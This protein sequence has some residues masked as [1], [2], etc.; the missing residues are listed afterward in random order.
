MLSAAAQCNCEISRSLVSALQCIV[1]FQPRSSKQ[2]FQHTQTLVVLYYRAIAILLADSLQPKSQSLGKNLTAFNA[3]IGFS[4]FVRDK[5]MNKCNFNRTD[6]PQLSPLIKQQGNDSEDIA[7]IL[8]AL[9]TL[10]ASLDTISLNIDQK[11][12]VEEDLIYT[13]FL[14]SCSQVAGPV[15]VDASKKLKQVINENG[16]VFSTPSLCKRDQCFINFID[17]WIKAFNINITAPIPAMMPPIA[18]SGAM[19]CYPSTTSNSPVMTPATSQSSDLDLLGLS[20]SSSTESGIVASMGGPSAVSLQLLPRTNAPLINVADVDTIEAVKN[21]KTTKAEFLYKKIIRDIL[22]FNQALRLQECVFSSKYVADIFHQYTEQV[23]AI[24]DG[25][26][27]NISLIP[28]ISELFDL[29]FSFDGDY[30]DTKIVKNQLLYCAQEGNYEKNKALLS[31]NK[32]YFSLLLALLELLCEVDGFIFQLHNATAIMYAKSTADACVFTLTQNGR[33]ITSN[34]DGLAPSLDK[35]YYHTMLKLKSR[36]ESIIFGCKLKRT[37]YYRATDKIYKYWVALSNYER[38]RLALDEELKRLDNEYK[39]ESGKGFF[40]KNRTYLAS[41]E[42]KIRKVKEDQQ[43]NVLEN[44]IV[45]EAFSSCKA[46]LDNYFG[47]DTSTLSTCANLQKEMANIDNKIAIWSRAQ[48]DISN[49]LQGILVSNPTLSESEINAI[50][51]TVPL[52]SI[53]C[54]NA[55]AAEEQVLEMDE[56]RAIDKSLEAGLQKLRTAFE[57]YSATLNPKDRSKLQQYNMGALLSN[58]SQV[59]LLGALQQQIQQ[60]IQVQIEQ[61]EQI[62]RYLSNYLANIM[63][64]KDPERNYPELTLGDWNRNEKTD[65]VLN[66]ALFEHAQNTQELYDWIQAKTPV[67]HYDMID[68]VY[69]FPSQ[70]CWWESIKFIKTAYMCEGF[71]FD[72]NAVEEENK[73]SLTVCTLDNHSLRVNLV[74]YFSVNNNPPIRLEVTFIVNK[75]NSVVTVSNVGF[76][77]TPPPE[78]QG[79]PPLIPTVHKMLIQL[80]A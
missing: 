17:S 79:L 6:L 29:V 1:Q 41:L 67:T 74:R 34:K 11:G 68:L 27:R 49:I 76:Q 61:S 57:N 20:D 58:Q 60:P 24:L 78:A 2:K 36:I 12:L 59:S 80:S 72:E 64:N 37:Q 5:L 23:K 14:S 50:E 33:V 38:E 18:I 10:F 66:N 19:S 32:E 55:R 25:D 71:T 16:A 70:A 77:M 40:S 28:F 44:G 43:Q 75:Q 21:L 51:D 8:E 65:Y 73:H 39:I 46:G 69:N 53:N 4:T 45:L 22:Q 31:R 13:S 30:C 62:E 42:K 26:Y 63:N 7:S 47:G 35:R 56:W 54:K 48:A 9:V 52:A 3:V 15:V